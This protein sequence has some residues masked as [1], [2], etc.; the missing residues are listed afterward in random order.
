MEL[1]RDLR[2]ALRTLGRAPLFA[3]VVVLTLAVAIGA[4]VALY[5]VV[6]AVLLSPLPF[7]EPDRLVA[8]WDAAPA[9]RCGC[10]GR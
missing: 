2:L 10:G 1:F 4:N 6:D 5:A 7:P 9:S 3:V 8:V